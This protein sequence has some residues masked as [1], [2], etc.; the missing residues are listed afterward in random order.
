MIRLHKKLLFGRV[1]SEQPHKWKRAVKKFEAIPGVY[2]ITAAQNPNHALEIY[3]LIQ[4]QQ[5]D[6]QYRDYLVVGIAISRDEAFE[7]VRQITQD[8]YEQLGEVNLRKFLELEE[9]Q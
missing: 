1:A 6:M 4:F 8:A 5:P 3:D 2:V 7:L 9:L